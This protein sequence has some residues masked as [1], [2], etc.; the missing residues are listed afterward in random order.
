MMIEHDN[1]NFRNHRHRALLKSGSEMHYARLV[2]CHFFCLVVSA[3]SA[4]GQS[5]ADVFV[6]LQNEC[7]SIEGASRI[8][9]GANYFVRST[10]DFGVLQAMVQ[11]NATF[12]FANIIFNDHTNTPIKDY[13]Q[14]FKIFVNQEELYLYSIR[15][16][17]LARYP[18][19]MKKA[20]ELIPKSCFLSFFPTYWTLHRSTGLESIIKHHPFV[21]TKNANVLSVEI[22]PVNPVGWPKSSYQFDSS[23]DL[24]VKY[25]RCETDPV[26]RL[27]TLWEWDLSNDKPFLKKKVCVSSDKASR[28]Q[29]EQTFRKLTE[30][31]I[32]SLNIRD[33]DEFLRGIPGGTKF[34]EV[35]ID[36]KIIRSHFLGDSS[37]A[38]SD[39]ERRRQGEQLRL[40]RYL[41]EKAGGKK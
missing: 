26:I 22:K 31:E 20:V 5:E 40:E 23:S 25:T 34:I 27:T 28:R 17:Y 19:N 39:Y 14:H 41:S 2:V 7:E 24:P 33:L 32:Q 38:E 4:F 37:T 18:F 29:F 3:S 6:G 11:S 13:D 30:N 35:G 36:S 10:D 8:L 16:C 1:P 9:D 12:L 15:E 21:V